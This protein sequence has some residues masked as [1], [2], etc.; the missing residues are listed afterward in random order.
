[1]LDNKFPLVWESEKEFDDTFC[2]ALID[3]GNSLQLEEGEV[4]DAHIHTESRHSKISW[5]NTPELTSVIFQYFQ[6]ANHESG[7]NFDLLGV[8]PLQFSIYEKD[9][10]YSWHTDTEG[11]PMMDG[12]RK[13]SMSIS[14]N[15]DFKGG[16]FEFS[17]GKPS[18][19]YKKR[20]I[21]TPLLKKKGSIV[22]FPSLLWHRVKPV[23]S[24]I[25]Y[26]LVA[27]AVGPPF[28]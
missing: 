3:I 26:S 14:L 18:K 1:M 25:R 19:P 20:I 5:I 15:E 7:W 24:G 9:M 21:T 6:R 16:D 11:F 28:R 17:W 27:W 13:L 22:I 23:I 2:S 10:F 12:V 8:E 4:N